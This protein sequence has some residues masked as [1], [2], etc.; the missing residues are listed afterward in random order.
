[1][2]LDN[3][4]GHCLSTENMD[5]AVRAEDPL[6][7]TEFFDSI[8]RWSLMKY[9]LFSSWTCFD[10]L[11]LLQRNPLLTIVFS[12]KPG[13]HRFIQATNT[14]WVLICSGG[15]HHFSGWPNLLPFHEA[16]SKASLW[17][18]LY[19]SCSAD[20]G[21]DVVGHNTFMQWWYTVAL[22]RRNR[23]AII[24]SWIVYN[25]GNFIFEYFSCK[26]IFH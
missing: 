24:L 26:S 3:E 8:W 20:E 12:L 7:F 21:P 6:P 5:I 13:R 19:S 23:L 4:E 14:D 9:Q 2:C 16:F 1:M 17:P 25:L 18:A 11:V 22:F 15:H 10:M